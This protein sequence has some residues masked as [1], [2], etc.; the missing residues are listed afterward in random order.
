MNNHLL[1][2]SCINDN[3]HVKHLIYLYFYDNAVLNPCAI[4]LINVLKIPAF[5]K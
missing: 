5:K 3:Y 1:T 4:I 2:Y